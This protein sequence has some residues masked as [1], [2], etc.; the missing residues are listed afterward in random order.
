MMPN[1]S[2]RVQASFRGALLVFL[3]AVLLFNTV[4]PA[5]VSA[6]GACPSGRRC[7]FIP[8][9]K[10]PAQQSGDLSIHNI[11]VTQAVQDANNSIPL[12]AGRNTLLRV[13]ARTTGTTTPMSNVKISVTANNGSF[14]LTESPRAV[15]ATVPL[16]YNRANLQSTI[17]ITL[18]ASWMTG[19]VSLTVRLDPDNQIHE[20]SESNNTLTKKFTF[21]QV[22]PLQIKIVPIKYVNLKDGRTYA[23]PTK[24]SI[25]DWILRTYPVPDVQISWHAPFTFTGDLSRGDEFRRLLSQVTELKNTEKAPNSQVYYALVPTSSSGHTW[26]YGGVA[27]VGWI[28]ARTAVGLDVSGTSGEIAAHEIGHNLGLDHSP[29]GVPAG[30]NPSFPYSDGSIGQLGIDT[31]AGVLYPTTTK[32]VMSYCSPKWVSDYT[33]R[34]LFNAQRAVGA[35]V[36][37]ANVQAAQRGLLVRAVIDPSG[38]QLKPAYVLPGAVDVPADGGEYLVETLDAQG[39]V[40]S[41]TPVRAYEAAAED[42]V[43]YAAINTMIP[44]PDSP[45]A[46]FQLVKDGQVVASQA[47][48]VP[49]PQPLMNGQSLQSADLQIISTRSDLEAELAQINRPAMVQYSTDGGASWTTLGLDITIET[50]PDLP[51][52]NVIYQ[53]LASE[54]WQ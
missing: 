45:A 31:Y 54:T 32:D 37:A 44:L 6:A 10:S 47:L 13:Y 11:E 27:G 14:M 50:I 34:S 3:F 39:A 16:N 35:Y 43:P 1:R 49:E 23:A 48:H 38:V 42:N 24:D 12:V 33:Y 28:G 36:Q 25:R 18:P 15:S 46:S 29:C 52:E 51:E 21:H 40:L 8:L 26:F 20:T 7:A 41:Q 9:V 19:D 17:N 2:L 53:V 22:A 4:Q 5:T 30:T